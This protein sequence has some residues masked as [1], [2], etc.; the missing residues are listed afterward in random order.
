M[1]LACRR[2]YA[3]REKQEARIRES[4][5]N[6][7]K[8][9]M[10]T[11]FIKYG[12]RL[13]LAVLITALLAACGS[14]ATAVPTNEPHSAET[15]PPVATAE[16]QPPVATAQV[17]PSG[18][19]S[20]TGETQVGEGWAV[21]CLG[22]WMNAVI[23]QSGNTVVPVQVPTAPAATPIPGAPTS[24]NGVSLPSTAGNVI[25]GGPVMLYLFA[26][27]MTLP[28]NYVL[29]AEGAAYQMLSTSGATVLSTVAAFATPLVVI[30]VA[31]FVAYGLTAL[32]AVPAAIVHPPAIAAPLANLTFS[33]LSSETFAAIVEMEVATGINITGKQLEAV[34]LPVGFLT[35][36]DFQKTIRLPGGTVVSIRYT[37]V[38]NVCNTTAD[39]KIKFPWKEENFQGHGFGCDPWSVVESVE[40][41]IRDFTKRIIDLNNKG[42][43]QVPIIADLIQ[44]TVWDLSMLSL[45]LISILLKTGW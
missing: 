31:T 29:V 39:M 5:K 3:D 10:K 15:Q 1:F 19:C 21:V 4:K 36:N 41:L 25:D 2:L 33:N 12:T 7:V 38:G 43:G 17:A 34:V 23:D 35:F 24:F 28:A 44:Q 9:T 14:P 6:E 45:T 26:G 30:G 27:S 40:Q 18:A 11:R 42:V 32:V 13:V 16:T 8:K 37:R 20:N 22:V